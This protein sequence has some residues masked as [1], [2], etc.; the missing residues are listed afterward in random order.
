MVRI[1]HLVFCLL[2]FSPIVVGKLAAQ[3]DTL[4]WFVAPE[5]Q[6]SHGDR[7]ISLRISTTQQAAS[8]TVSMPI[9]L[10]FP[11]VNLTIPPNTTQS[12][13]LTPWVDLLENKPA[14]QILDKGLRI[15]STSPITAYYEVVT[16]CNC[17]P[18][19]FTLKG[20]NALGTQ[21]MLPFQNFLANG[22]SQSFSGFDIVATENATSITINPTADI[23][24][25]PAG[26]PFTVILN[27]GETWSG[28]SVSQSAN[29][30]PAGT[31]VISD[32]PIA[33]TIK[34]DS[35]NGAPYGGCADLMGDQLVPIPILG[36]EYITL[37]GYLNGPDRVFVL[38]TQNN[39]QITID[40]NIVGTLNAGQTYVHVQSATTAYIQSSFPVYVLHTTGFGCEVGGAV[41]PPVRCTGSQQIGFTRSTTEFFALNLMVET[42]GEGN[43]TLNGNPG[44][45]QSGNF[46]PVPGSGGNW[47][48]A[49]IQFNTSD[50]PAGQASLIQNSSH[51]FH[52]GIINGGASSGCRYGYF[53]DYSAYQF[54]ASV[55]S[56]SL[57]EGADL[58]LSANPLPGA[59]YQWTGPNNFTSNQ[60]FDT[61][62]GALPSDSGLYLLTGTVGACPVVSD[63]VFIFIQA[64]PSPAVA[65]PIP[66][67]CA[68]SNGLLSATGPGSAQFE[69]S[70]PGGFFANQ[71]QVNLNGL[72][73][74]QSGWYT[75][76]PFVNGC[77]GDSD[78]VFLLV[79]SVALSDSLVSLLCHN[80]STGEIHMQTTQGIAP[81]QFAW[82]GG[83]GPMASQT[84]LT[85]GSYTV[86]VTD[87][88]GCQVTDT[89]SLI[90]PA[91]LNLNLNAS[92]AS[93]PSSADGQVMANAS[94]GTGPL[95]PLWSHGPQSFNP[96]N[97]PGGW[98]HFT[99][100]DSNGCQKSDSIQVSAPPPLLAQVDSLQAPSCHNDQNGALFVSGSGGPGS[101]GY[102]WQHNSS[103]QANQYN[104]GAGAYTVWVFDNQGCDTLQ[105]DTVLPN[106]PP[107]NL[108]VQTS[109]S[110]VCPGVPVLLDAQGTTHYQWSG[111]GI[112][113]PN[114][115]SQVLTLSQSSSFQVIGS[116]GPCADTATLWIEVHPQPVAAFQFLAACAQD[117]LWLSSATSS[118]P[119]PSQL[120]QYYWDIDGDQIVD[121]QSGQTDWHALFAQGGS[122]PVQLVVESSE[123]C[124]D[125][126]MQ[127]VKVYPLPELDFDHDGVCIDQTYQPKN[128]SSISSGS[129]L[130]YYW[131]FG[132]G[133][134][135]VGNSIPNSYADTGVYIVTLMAESDEGCRDTFSKPV[136]I[137][138][139]PEV[140]LITE[141]GCFRE[142]GYRLE[143]ISG[144][145]IVEPIL[146]F[147]GDNSEVEGNPTSYVYSQAGTYTIQVEI[148]D[149]NGCMGTA[150]DS[151]VVEHTKSWEEIDFPNLITA[152]GDG[153]NDQLL[154]DPDIELCSPYTILVFN[155]W[156]RIVY[157]GS[158]E[159]D[160]PFEG[161]NQNGEKLVTGVYQYIIKGET[162][163]TTQNLHIFE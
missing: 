130:Q 59:T 79:D 45:I 60:Q 10:G 87:S 61:L 122:I 136:N 91:A 131:D 81:F 125:T 92:P 62:F 11:S 46:N 58:Y 140:L 117:S 75:V 53:S 139:G 119:A 43:F 77:P 12:L 6:Q 52:M 70:G 113:Q 4:F 111:P 143:Q 50:I 147:T 93:C 57:C 158:S 32:K 126:L 40:G 121:F 103:N 13:D 108:H 89:L 23:V 157:Q 99:V 2:F 28:V 29:Q 66:P 112:N 144:D 135:G 31:T 25:H 152:N 51:L 5:V 138:L 145:S 56:D 90:N 155:R 95:T 156:G 154:L 107:V 115:S 94:G 64:T 14:N 36:Q 100:T 22:V 162:F 65:N 74:N 1:R 142:V 63:S 49:Q 73:T 123:G 16:G 68:G 18:D 84:G 134:T 27:A 110:L 98:Y 20:K 118:V 149:I 133:Q 55:S 86:Q 76:R 88:L 132:D 160:T 109:D 15:Q 163:N 97:V 161:K 48:Y 24:G 96:P 105:L 137:R 116:N 120:V 146:W 42:G 19:I 80:D 9:N 151:V 128:Q 104:L 34:D 78:Q 8:V 21:F 37:K 114:D 17:N 44:L 30:R 67:Q 150:E 83:L 153:I 124:F 38:A 7:P 127:A 39:T 26:V 82:S 129:I 69:W 101:I 54:Q 85:A 141:T 106:P 33:I 148:T 159:N 47:M 72:Q 35:M 71:A 41:L 102:L 3:T